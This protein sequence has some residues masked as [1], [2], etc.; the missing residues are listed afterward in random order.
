M[1]TIKSFGLK[2]RYNG[3]IADGEGVVTKVVDIGYR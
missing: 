2:I 1:T 3:G